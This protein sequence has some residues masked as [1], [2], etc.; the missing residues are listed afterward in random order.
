MTAFCKVSVFIRKMAIEQSPEQ[1]LLEDC[2]HYRLYRSPKPNN[3]SHN[4]HSDL[5]KDDCIQVM[6]AAIQL[7][8]DYIWHKESFRLSFTNENGISSL[9]GSTRFGDALEDEWFIVYVL[10]KIT[11]EFP[12]LIVSV[13]DTDGDFLLIEAADSLPDWLDPSTS[14][15]RVFIHRGKLHIIPIDFASEKKRL[16]LQK[17]IALVSDLSI[18]TV[19]SASIQAAI[20]SRIGIF[21]AGISTQKHRSNVQVPLKVAQLLIQNPQLISSAVNAFITRDPI[22]MRPCQTMSVFDPATAVEMTAT[23]TKIMYSQ[24]MCQRFY[25]PSKF[26]LPLQ[27]SSEFPAYELGMK[28]TCGFEI[29]YNSSYLQSTSSKVLG[30]Q[31]IDSYDFTSDPDWRKFNEKLTAGFYFK[32][33]VQGSKLYTSLERL[34]KQQ[35][36]DSKISSTDMSIENAY[37][38]MCHILEVLPK[39]SESDIP[40]GVVDS[41]AWMHLDPVAIDKDLANRIDKMSSKLAEMDEH[42]DAMSELS[43]R[44]VAELEQFKSVF[45]GFDSFVNKESGLEGAEFPNDIDSKDEWIKD[46]D[47]SEN[48]SDSNSDQGVQLDSKK[49]MSSIMKI[50]GTN[51]SVLSADMPIQSSSQDTNLSIVQGNSNRHNAFDTR[52]Q[53]DSDDEDDFVEPDYDAELRAYMDSMDRELFASKLGADFE[54]EQVLTT[55]EN[56]P[57]TSKTTDDFIGDDDNEMENEFRPVDLD[58]NLLKNV[59]ESFASQQGLAGPASNIMMSMG[60]NLPRRDEHSD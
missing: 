23:F 31:T 42:G 34:A 50:L 29:L 22:S 10:Y 60:L 39:I 27:S 15:N 33:Q 40:R 7:I 16:A 28:L 17:A 35:Y 36:L 59:F 56:H 5:N 18:P 4:Q 26:R 44:D 14:E 58:V 46:I 41:D 20:E 32:N 38:Q 45:K 52:Q 25:P 1:L 57:S 53:A 37:D 2:V 8:G 24:L 21:P 49:F 11:L 3:P 6:A 48:E 9:S 51:D 55:R 12:D 43:D 54:R 19:A 30:T 47:S 13:H